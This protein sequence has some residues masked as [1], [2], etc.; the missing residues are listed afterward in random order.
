MRVRFA[1]PSPA[2]VEHVTGVSLPLAASPTS[3]PQSIGQVCSVTEAQRSS[4]GNGDQ[5]DQK[6]NAARKQPGFFAAF[7]IPAGQVYPRGPGTR[8]GPRSDR[9]STA[10][11]P[12]EWPTQK[13]LFP[14]RLMPLPRRVGSAGFP[15]IPAHSRARLV[16]CPPRLRTRVRLMT[17]AL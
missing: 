1:W 2:A 15:A 16:W 7:V 10:K 4:S 9:S 13:P 12:L 3:L 11:R 6:T 8:P 14:A 5:F 17:G